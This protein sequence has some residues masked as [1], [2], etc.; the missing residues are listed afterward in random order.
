M[1]SLS[2][3]LFEDTCIPNISILSFKEPKSH[4]ETTLLEHDF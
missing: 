3:A 2:C 1:P 4:S